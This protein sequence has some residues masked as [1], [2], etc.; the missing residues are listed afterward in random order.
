[1]HN[2]LTNAIKSTASSRIGKII[3]GL[4]L[5]ETRPPLAGT[6]AAVSEFDETMNS[7]PRAAVDTDVAWLLVPIQEE[8]ACLKKPAASS[9]A[10]DWP[11][12]ARTSRLADLVDTLADST[13]HPSLLTGALSILSF[14]SGLGLFI[15]RRIAE[16]LG[17][18]INVLSERG[19]GST[20]T[21]CIPAKWC[22]APFSSCADSSQSP[23]TFQMNSPMV[24]IPLPVL[25][26]ETVT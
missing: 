19:V 2:L 17:G 6:I 15:C 26:P 14:Q 5:S 12:R 8:I 23:D 16:Q 22:N 11:T 10:L 18:A 13:V 1:M 24:Q 21:F 25:L 9:N 20:F 3:V 7:A 4:D